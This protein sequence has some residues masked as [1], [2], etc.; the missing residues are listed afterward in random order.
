MS[1]KMG[2][3][4][5]ETKDYPVEQVLKSMDR[6]IRLGG[7]AFIKWTCPKCGERVM[8]D[9]PNVYNT[10]GYMHVEK[11]DGSQCGGLYTG[12]MF[13]FCAVFARGTSK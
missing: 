6:V 2:E 4:A 11:A 13:N 1:S 8:S 3:T 7:L 12:E 10:A 9:T 5:G